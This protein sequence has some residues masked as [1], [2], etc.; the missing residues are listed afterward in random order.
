MES[1][2]KNDAIGLFASLK[3]FAA[4]LRTAAVAVCSLAVLLCGIYPLTVWGVARGLFPRQANGSLI[5][6]ADR[7]LGSSLIGQSFS[8]AS[9]FHPRPSA[10]GNGYDAAASGGS[11][12][13]PT[14]RQLIDSVRQRLARYR[15]ENGLEEDDSVP[16]DAVTGSASGLDPHISLDNAI[17]QGRRVARARGLS[18]QAMRRK[19]DAHTSGRDLGFLGEPRVNVLELNLDLDGRW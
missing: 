14:A 15:T 5:V 16:A 10:A 1:A 4:E 8:G 18:E 12:L 9:Y 11:N 17:L 7:V 13:G 6:R 3:Q 2:V 19:I